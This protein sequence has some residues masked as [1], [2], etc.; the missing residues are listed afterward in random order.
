MQQEFFDF[1]AKLFRCDVTELTL[2]TSY[3]GIP[4]WDSLMQIRLAIEIEE[5]YDLSIPLEEIAE[6][7]TL[8][9]LYEWICAAKS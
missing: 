7:K 9:E 1:V 8:G 4:A 6:L 3:Q 5:Y 2:E